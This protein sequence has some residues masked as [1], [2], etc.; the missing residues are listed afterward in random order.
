MLAA[1][2]IAFREGLE[3]ALIVG[4]VL[5][6]LKRIERLEQQRYVWGGVIAAIIASLGVPLGLQLI[7]AQLTGRAE[8][9]FEGNSMFLAVGVRLAGGGAQT[10]EMPPPSESDPFLL[11]LPGSG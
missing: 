8:E 11:S 2:L 3:A 5:G 1:G 7:G 4:I 9:I 6:Y 10:S